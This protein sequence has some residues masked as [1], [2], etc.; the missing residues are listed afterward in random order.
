M[1]NPYA[2]TDSNLVGFIN[3]I[4]LCRQHNVEGF[5]YASSSSVYGKNSKTPFSTL[6]PTDNP[7]SLYAATKKANELV[8]H[9]YSHLYNLNTTGLRFLQFM[10]HGVVQIW[11]I[12]NLLIV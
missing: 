5:I 12:I 7:I 10:A 6:D 4:E 3:V 8:A 2:Y 11:L 9:S 1:K